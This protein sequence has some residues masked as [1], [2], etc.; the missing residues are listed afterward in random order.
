MQH[1]NEDGDQRNMQLLSY[2]QHMKYSYI[3]SYGA[4]LTYH[5]TNS[6]GL[7]K[8]ITNLKMK[9]GSN[10]PMQGFKH[11]CTSKIWCL[12]I[13]NKSLP[14]RDKFYQLPNYNKYPCGLTSVDIMLRLS[15]TNIQ[16]TQHLHC[17]STCPAAL[18]NDES[19]LMK[20]ARCQ[21]VQQHNKS[22]SLRIWGEIFQHTKLLEYVPFVNDFGFLVFQEVTHF[23]L[24]R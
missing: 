19:L 13:N 4:I 11:K 17:Q 22:T 15:D 23:R 2:E 18:H 14:A 20:V 10:M 5:W 3:S 7:L 6:N 12:C 1:C 16:S 21:R 8:I 9:Q 24:S